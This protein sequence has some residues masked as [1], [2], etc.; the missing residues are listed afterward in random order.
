M[1]RRGIE[2]GAQAPVKAQDGLSARIPV[3][4]EGELPPVGQ[5]DRSGHA[6]CI[7]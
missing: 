3:L 1:G 4:L 6:G 5:G 7:C 2:P